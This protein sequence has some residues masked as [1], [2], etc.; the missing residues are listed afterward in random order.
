MAVMT[1]TIDT[2]SHCLMFKIRI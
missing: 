2:K 1:V